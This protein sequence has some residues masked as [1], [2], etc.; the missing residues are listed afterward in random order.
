[1]L[2]EADI[3]AA[4]SQAPAD[5]RISN[6]DADSRRTPRAES[7]K[8]E[9]TAPPDSLGLPGRDEHLRR[10]GDFQNL[11]D[12]GQAFRGKMMVLILMPNGRGSTRCGFVASGRVGGAV[13]RNRSKRVLREAYRQLRA[14]VDLSGID[15]IL[16][17]GPKCKE[18]KIHLV[19]QELQ[20]LYRV[21]GVWI[22]SP[23]IPRDPAES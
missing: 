21:G 8:G 16:I 18:A 13:A 2:S 23:G 14:E 9:G 1:V 17:A 22:S 20:Q 12:R 7:A 15:L 19:V 10:R 6:S 11:Y 3:P 5:A 4:S